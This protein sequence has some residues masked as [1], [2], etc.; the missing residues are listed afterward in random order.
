MK[1]KYSRAIKV[2]GVITGS[3]VMLLSGAGF[4]AIAS[5]MPTPGMIQTNPAI[6]HYSVKLNPLN[7]S[8]VTGI[9][10]LTLQ[11]NQLTV[12]VDATGL[13]P[14]EPHAQHIHGLLTPDDASCPTLAQDI[15]HDNNISVD[16]GAATYGP[17]KLNLTSPQTAFG[18]N[19][20]T[21]NGVKLFAPFAGVPNPNDF[22]VPT[23]NGISNHSGVEHFS[24]TYTFGPNDSQAQAALASLTPL[25]NQEIVLHG[26][27]VKN[28]A[29]N[30]RIPFMYDPLQPVACGEVVATD[31][32]GSGSAGSNGNTN[33]K[34]RAAL[35]QFDKVVDPAT[36]TF[37]SS[38]AQDENSLQ[39]VTGGSNALS[40]FFSA[41]RT[42]NENFYASV[43]A[44]E[45]QFRS[46]ANS[47]MSY[48]Q[49]RNTFIDKF[50]HAKSDYFNSL[51]QAKNT[52]SDNL[53]RDGQAPAKDQFM[54]SFNEQSSR[55]S[56][57]LEQA[58]NQL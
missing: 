45:N 1:L 20:T 55:Y 40:A 44:A 12:A 8:G 18:P 34:A 48:D 47:G 7:D 49:A 3:L 38:V 23:Q 35:T 13:V 37:Q 43:N 50:N 10:N 5:A 54:N 30:S 31:Q 19:E 11:G 17:I 56:N 33:D 27:L 29:P 32:N 46:D 16:E 21:V 41:S 2:L 39:N 28:T 57:Q 14:G 24:Y 58:K 9:A 53:N 25:S 42:A 15:N 26:D 4:P 52:L 22:P 36:S 6:T 51:E